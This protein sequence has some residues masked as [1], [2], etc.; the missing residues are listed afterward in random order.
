TGLRGMTRVT[1]LGDLSLVRPLLAIPKSRLTA[2][3]AAAKIPFAD[4]P[5]NRDPRFARPR[6]RELMPGLAAEGLAARRLVVLGPR[7]ARADQAIERA[8]GEAAARLVRKPG[9]D[10]GLIVLRSGFA[11]LPAEV[12]L[13]L[14]GR[15]ITA[16]GN[17]GPVE[18]GKLE[19]LHAEL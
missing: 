4:D 8:T 14:L 19:A 15:A 13:R 10:G 18:L 6:L 12:A 17:E 5:S 7:M 1:P 3:L 9:G 2:T 16:S 11:E